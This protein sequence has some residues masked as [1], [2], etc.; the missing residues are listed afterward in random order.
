MVKGTIRRYPQRGKLYGYHVSCPACGFTGLHMD[1]SE[2]VV[3][4]EAGPVEKRPA[5]RCGE[6]VGAGCHGQAHQPESVEIRGL[7]CFACRRS[8]TVSAGEIVAE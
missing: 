3:V 7:R 8:I 2:G 6:C 1:G 5:R 4:V